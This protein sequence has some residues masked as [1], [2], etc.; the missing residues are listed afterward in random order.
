MR[1]H[2][3]CT[4]TA[5][6][7]TIRKQQVLGSNPSVGSTP[8]GWAERLHDDPGPDSLR[9][10]ERGT[11]VAQVVEALGRQTCR[12]HDRLGSARHRDA[13]HRGTHRRGEDEIT[14]VVAPTRLGEEVLPELAPPAVSRFPEHRYSERRMDGLHERP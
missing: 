7:R 14:W 5:E 13:I 2:S 3:R 1:R 4:G 8:S 10:E 6:G 12:C 11:G 9:E